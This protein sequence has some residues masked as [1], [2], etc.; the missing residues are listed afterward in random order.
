MAPAVGGNFAGI[1]VPNKLTATRSAQNSR[2]SPLWPD[3]A[4]KNCRARSDRLRTGYGPLF[5]LRNG[6]SL[7]CLLADCLANVVLLGFHRVEITGVGHSCLR[8]REVL[9]S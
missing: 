4:R 9:R 7:T 6:S 2:Q 8:A 1:P 3:P 5:P